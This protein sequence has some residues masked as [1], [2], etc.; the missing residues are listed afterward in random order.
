MIA[1]LAALALG[2]IIASNASACADPA[3][4]SA[5]LASTQRNGAL[6]DFD[7]VIV[8]KNV[9]QGAQ[10]PSLLQS[11]QVFQDATKVGQ[12]GLRPLAAGA[13]QTVHYELQR[14]A[15]GAAGSTRLRFVLVGHDPHGLPVTNCSTSNDVFR[16]TV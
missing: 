2:P 13:S 4:V 11:V 1:F 16:L 14:S 9:G 15:G 7:T 6:D 8:V 10:A 5:S 3:I 12:I